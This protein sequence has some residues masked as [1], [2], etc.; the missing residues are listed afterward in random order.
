LGLK[1]MVDATI[2]TGMGLEMSILSLRR[3]SDVVG[4]DIGCGSIKAMYL[5]RA[6]KTYALEKMGVADLP[7]GSFH[8]GILDINAV[9]KTL[10][11]LWDNLEFKKTPAAFAVPGRE[12][13]VDIIQLEG[14]EK[15]AVYDYIVSH[16]GEYLHYP[17]EEI[18]FDCDMLSTTTDKES[19]TSSIILACV[20]K[21][22]LTDFR[23]IVER[24]GI[25]VSIVDIDYFALYN[26]FEAAYG[27]PDPEQTIV[28]LDFG[29]SKINIV[30][31]HDGMP[32]FF[33]TV[34]SGVE[35]II[36][37][38]GDNLGLDHYSATSIIRGEKPD[39]VN[40]DEH[41]VAD[42]V[43]FVF[44]QWLS[45]IKHNVEY[46]VNMQGVDSIDLIYASGGPACAS[47]LDEMIEEEMSVP[48]RILN[49]LEK[50]R[51][52]KAIDPDYVQAVGPQMAVCFG[53]AMR[54]TGDK[55]L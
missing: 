15:D 34:S 1:I 43:K 19:G 26:A 22:I 38:L 54:R 3:Q 45:E 17:L 48:C 44:S 37:Q 36:F 35:E 40:I 39:N 23:E 53:I 31:I 21:A 16:A 6:G 18:F 46:F 50:V 30:I 24:T 11:N 47:G 14:V 10:R 12:V 2:K 7:P 25:K 42:I 41:D 52:K 55:K 29:H 51:L 27:P 49:P 13:I 4:I 5:K 20:K 32:V 33:R 9:S 8:N 28:L